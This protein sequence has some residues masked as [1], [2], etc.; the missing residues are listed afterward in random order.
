VWHDRKW[1]LYRVQ[2]ATPIAA[3]PA[4][5]T[6]IGQSSMT[7]KVPCACTVAVRLRWSKFLT[8][9]LQTPG[10]AGDVARPALPLIVAAVDGDDTGWTTITTTRPGSYR[11]SGSIS[12]IFHV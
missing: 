2:D 10:P 5:I 8:A 1:T 11:L 12:G 6:F 4:T 9:Q 3:A 7:I